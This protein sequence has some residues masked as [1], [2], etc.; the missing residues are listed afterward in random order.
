MRK[1]T[2]KVS[3]Q[4]NLP[5]EGETRGTS[6]AHLPHDSNNKLKEKTCSCTVRT[7]NRPWDPTNSRLRHTHN[8]GANSG[9]LGIRPAQGWPNTCLAKRGEKALV[10]A[11]LARKASKQATTKKSAP[12]QNETPP[13]S[14]EGTAK[15]THFE[16]P[17]LP[18]VPLGTRTDDPESPA[19]GE[20]SS[21]LSSRVA[22]V[23]ASA[24]GEALFFN[25]VKAALPSSWGS[26]SGCETGFDRP[27]WRNAVDLGTVSFQAIPTRSDLFRCRATWNK[28]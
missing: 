4:L 19:Q 5:M 18:R 7:G 8:L 22:P 13:F 2:P 28:G 17:K 11:S 20:P 26:K 27:S 16:G 10:Q 25:I 6:C 24:H 9:N 12:Q 23:S 3:G 14:S 15:R 21:S 1:V